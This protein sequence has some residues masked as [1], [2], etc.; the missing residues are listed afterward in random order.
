MKAKM[1]PFRLFSLYIELAYVL[2]NHRSK[3]GLGAVAC[4]LFFLLEKRLNSS[5]IAPLCN[6]FTGTVASYVVQ[7]PF[8]AF[9][10]LPCTQ[11]MHMHLRTCSVQH[12]SW[13]VCLA[14]WLSVSLQVERNAWGER[15]GAPGL[16]LA[17]SRM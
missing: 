1:L 2:P 12:N 13:S 6:L 15:C 7:T 4:I 5:K 11:L 8:V 9:D 10:L 17:E 3:N 14:D 16:T